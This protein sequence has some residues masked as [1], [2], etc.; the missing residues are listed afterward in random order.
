MHPFSLWSKHYPILPE[1]VVID[2]C[3]NS[4]SRPERIR[5]SIYATIDRHEKRCR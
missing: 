1:Q 2:D 5:K 4:Y 3:I